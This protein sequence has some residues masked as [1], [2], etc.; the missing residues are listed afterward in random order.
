[1]IR[2]NDLCEQQQQKNPF[3]FIVKQCDF[4]SKFFQIKNKYPDY[5]I[6]IPF[7]TS[8]LLLL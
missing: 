7:W 8:T 5:I 1:M 6:H 3:W 4:F 2:S